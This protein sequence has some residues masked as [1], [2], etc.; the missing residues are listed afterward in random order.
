MFLP[1]DNI[2]QHRW[3]FLLMTAVVCFLTAA[4]MSGIIVVINMGFGASDLLPFLV[5]SLP[6]A[7]VIALVKKGLMDILHQLSL[8]LRYIVAAVIGIIGGVLWTYIVAFFLGEWFGAFS[9]PVLPCWIASGASGL[10]IGTSSH[11]NEGRPAV[12]ELLLVIMIGLCSMTVPKYL[13]D[14][15]SNNQKIEVVS[16]KWK[17]SLDPLTVQ[18]SSNLNV[19]DNSRL[20]NEDMTNLESLGLSGQIDYAGSSGFVGRGKP[21]R[22]LIVMQHQLKEPVELKQPNGVNVIYIQNEDGWKMYPSDAPTLERDIRLWADERNPTWATLYSIE[23]AD[24]TRQGSTLFT[25]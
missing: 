19:P 2:V 20:S 25:W 4:V 14:S 5:W 10:I 22:V 7:I 13:F 8:L 3:K 9:F 1:I 12:I 21:T 11:K 18:D 17:S 23:R 15:S 16:V 6:F 24:T